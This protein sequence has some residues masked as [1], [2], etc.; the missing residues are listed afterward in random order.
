[1]A[2]TQTEKSG[3][4]IIASKVYKELGLQYPDFKAKAAEIGIHVTGAIH[5]LSDEE[6]HRIKVHLGLIREEPP[7]PAISREEADAKALKEREEEAARKVIEDE[8][9]ARA[10]EA[11]RIEKARVDAEAARLAAEE[12]ARV[13][14]LDLLAKRLRVRVDQLDPISRTLGIVLTTHAEVEDALVDRVRLLEA[15]LRI[16]D[17]LKTDL[18]ALAD[19]GRSIGIEIGR[20]GFKGL[21]GNEEMV[22]SAMA[23]LKLKT[24][25]ERKA[26]VTPVQP[27]YQPA[28][29]T[30]NKATAVIPKK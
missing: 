24:A 19:M 16:A 12:T 20:K 5:K 3:T 18:K 25:Q 7:A 21:T 15:P 26:E 4:T 11:A 8:A 17:D 14:R 27:E 29:P 28:P 22:L 6:V 9:Q 13:S 23:K 1:M 10:D 30:C 2:A